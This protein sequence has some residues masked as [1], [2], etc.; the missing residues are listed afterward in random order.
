MDAVKDIAEA[1]RKIE[2]ALVFGWQDVAKRYR[3]SKVG[4]FWLTINMG[5]LISALGLIFGTLFRFDFR[6][7]LPHVAA[8]LIIWQYLTNTIMDGATSYIDSTNTILQVRMPL[9]THILRTLWRNTIIL[10]HNLVIIPLMYLVFLTPPPITLLLLPIGFALVV[11]NAVWMALLLSVFSTRFRDIPMVVQNFF[12][13]FFY[14][15]PIMWTPEVLPE[16]PAQ[17]LLN[18]NPFVH[19]LSLMRMPILG[20]VPSMENWIVCIVMAALGWCCALY[21]FN[22]FHHRVTYWL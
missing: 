1:L 19:L 10:G 16:G 11:V 5:V 6:E 9:F 22:R 20:Q 3:R 8:G 7:F 14:A 12:Q 13:V 21:V 2:I 15:T 4:A 18:L 17:M